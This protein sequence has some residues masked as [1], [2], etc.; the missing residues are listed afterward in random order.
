MLNSNHFNQKDTIL[1]QAY[2]PEE[3]DFKDAPAHSRAQV[4]KGKVCYEF[5]PS[6]FQLGNTKAQRIQFTLAYDTS[7]AKAA[8]V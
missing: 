1:F 3:R 4:K 8:L 2:D 5:I 6:L 7:L